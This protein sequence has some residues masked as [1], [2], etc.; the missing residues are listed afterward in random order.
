MDVIVVA[1][2][3]AL[4]M[5]VATVESICVRIAVTAVISSAA[6]MERVT[7]VEKM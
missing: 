5:S 3:N 1:A 4:H 6:V 2:I 7:A